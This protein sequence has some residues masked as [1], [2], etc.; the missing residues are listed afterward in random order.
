MHLDQSSAVSIRLLVAIASPHPLCHTA[1]PQGFTAGPSTSWAACSNRVY[2]AQL[3]PSQTGLQTHQL[4]STCL[5]GSTF[6]AKANGSP[7][8]LPRCASS[9]L[10]MAARPCTDSKST[11]SS[12]QN[13]WNTLFWCSWQWHTVHWGGKMGMQDGQFMS[14]NTL[15]CINDIGNKRG[16]HGNRLFWSNQCFQKFKLHFC[17]K[18]YRAYWNHPAGIPIA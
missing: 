1:W 8:V 11:A 4:L 12:P 13:P 15:E 14:S 6:K 17:K 18:S 16:L 10:Q 7:G 9:E 2:L 5:C 3:L